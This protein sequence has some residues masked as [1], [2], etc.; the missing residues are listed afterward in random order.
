MAEK[1]QNTKLISAIVIIAI[2]IISGI[3]TTISNGGAQGLFGSAGLLKPVSGE[4]MYVNFVDVG[5]GTCT[6]ITCGDTAILCDSGEASEGKKVINYLK[7]QG[8]KD[9]DLIIASHPHSDHIGSMAKVMNAFEIGDVIMPEIPE[10]IIPTTASYEKFLNAVS[11]RA[12]DVIPA[13]AGQTYE[14]GEL[15][16]DILGP[17][18]DYDDLNNMSV[19]AKISYGETSVM[20]TGDAET[21]AEND[22]LKKNYSFDANL[23]QVG[24]HGS[25]TSSSASWLKAVSPEYAVISCGL[26]NDY[27]HPHSQAIKRLEKQNIKYLRTDLLGDIVFSSDGKII[28]QVTTEKK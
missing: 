3:V 27:G 13:V 8:I 22:I 20:V 25:K 7:N 21:E 18:R 10:K 24:H 5:Q 16:V 4:K 2:L 9:I 11:E 12:T 23:L 17:V 26:N 1:K 14:Y 19:V 6:L 15:R 28:E